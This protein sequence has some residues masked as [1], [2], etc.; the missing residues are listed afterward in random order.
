MPY[1]FH[2]QNQTITV[3]GIGRV[4]A[5]VG[6][7]DLTQPK[8]IQPYESERVNH[9]QIDQL[10]ILLTHD[11]PLD[12]VTMGYGMEEIS[13]ILDVYAPAYHLHGHTEEHHIERKYNKTRVIKLSDLHWD[14]QSPGQ[15]VESASMGILRWTDRSNHRF[16]VVEDEWYT[17]YTAQNWQNL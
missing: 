3:L 9:A 16:E 11:T 7:T 4:G 14:E 5:L 8:L 1:T 10:D 6:E 15:S 12:F 13:L 2:K 17:M